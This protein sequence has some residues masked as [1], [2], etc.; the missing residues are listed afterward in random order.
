MID[1][2]LE[3]WSW[4]I[5]CFFSSLYHFSNKHRTGI[6]LQFLKPKIIHLPFLLNQEIPH[7]VY[8]QLSYSSI[9]QSLFSF[10][11]SVVLTSIEHNFGF[12]HKAVWIDLSIL[13][14]YLGGSA[15]IIYALHMSSGSLQSPHSFLCTPSCSEILSNPLSS[16]GIY[17]LINTQIYL[18]IPDL[19]SLIQLHQN[20][21]QK[22][23]L[24]YSR[25]SS[26]VSH[27]E[28]KKPWSC[29]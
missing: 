7:H 10:G 19:F 8:C 29:T 13:I 27:T 14:L 16:V 12:Q 15:F 26:K 25:C 3:T 4:L 11:S 5:L 9:Q 17:M 22:W 23:P 21:S 24:R 6:Y 18:F 28:K 1:I 2:F 20:A